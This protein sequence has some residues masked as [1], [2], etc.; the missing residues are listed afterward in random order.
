MRKIGT[1]K[2]QFAHPMQLFKFVSQRKVYGFT[3][4]KHQFHHNLDADYEPTLCAEHNSMN[5]FRQ[6]TS[7]AVERPKSYLKPS[8]NC[9]KVPS[10][11]A[12]SIKFADSGHRGAPHIFPLKLKFFAHSPR[13]SS[14]MFITRKLTHLLYLQ[15][16]LICLVSKIWLK[17]SLEFCLQ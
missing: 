15:R 13:T 4:D 1:H 10:Q 11:E 9:H 16:Q 3:K 6:D 7:V 5:K 12:S 17:L 8:K 14:S 2:F